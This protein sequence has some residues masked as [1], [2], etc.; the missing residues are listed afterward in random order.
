MRILVVGGGIAGLTTATV[1]G[2]LGHHVVVI[3]RTPDFATVGAGIGLAAGPEAVLDALQVDRAGVGEPIRRLEV[4]DAGG[5]VLQAVGADGARAYAR[6]DLHRALLDAAREVADI[7]GGMAPGAEDRAA[8]ELVVGA[9]GISSATRDAVVGPVGMRYSGAT[10]WRTI[11][12]NVGVDASFESW[13]DG[14]RVGG[15][16]L[17][18]GRLYCF[19]VRTCPRRSDGPADLATLQSWMAGIG[20][21]ARDVV[22]ALADLP[23]FHHDLDELG[24]PAWGDGAT[25]LVG[26]AAHAVTPNLGFGA[27]LAIEDAAALGLLLAGGCP[28]SAAAGA[29]RRSR[30]RRARR[31]QL[32][33][34]RIGQ[35]AQVRGT[36]GVRMRD[37]MAAATP[38]VV[39][40]RQQAVLDVPGHRLAARL[41]AVL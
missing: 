13:G 22:A 12:P 34:R 4:R 11:V 10:C 29:L 19:L 26:D 6:P 1:L 41:R 9:D 37:A 16:P 24:R 23:P 20:G 15:I 40:R 5:R 35:A 31:V 2:R 27:G 14:V 18:D 39:L 32:L 8:H 36:L 21:E 38:A 7:R 17:T 28:A 3:E 30:H 25:V 33:S